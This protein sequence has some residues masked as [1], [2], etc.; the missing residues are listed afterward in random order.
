MRYILGLFLVLAFFVVIIATI[1]HHSPNSKS[2]TKNGS[3]VVLTDYIDKNSEVHLYIDGEINAPEDH[4]AVEIIVS[5]TSRQLTVFQG[6][7][8]GVAFRQGF[9]NDKASYDN[10]M[11]AIGLL[12][13]VKERNVSQTN[14]KGVCPT[15]DR[16]IYE[17]RED[18]KNVTRLWAATCNKSLGTFAGATSSVN[19][20][21]QKQIPN[22][23]KLIEDFNNL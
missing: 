15:G 14:E 6:Y 18:G 11:H 1:L 5:P 7:N 17:L 4:Q 8:L 16:F 20:L 19:K 3:A 10:F 23:A 21:F 13:F 12:G 9:G 2:S 22:Y